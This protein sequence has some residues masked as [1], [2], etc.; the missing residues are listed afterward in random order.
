ML[1]YISWSI[2]NWQQLSGK[3]SEK[4]SSENARKIKEANV[5]Y[6]KEKKYSSKLKSVFI[7][8]VIEFDRVWTKYFEAI[9]SGGKS[10]ISKWSELIPF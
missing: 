9:L 4:Q 1:K 7:R 2:D 3:A 8:Y 6:T 10:N 5:N